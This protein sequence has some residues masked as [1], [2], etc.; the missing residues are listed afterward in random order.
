M[1]LRLRAAAAAILACVIAVSSAL[2]G[3]KSE[4]FKV[5]STLDGRKV[6]PLRIHWIAGPHIRSAKVEEVDFLI[7]GKVR[8]IEH[9]APYVYGG[10]DEGHNQGFLITTWLRP[11]KHRTVRVTNTRGLKAADTVIAQEAGRGP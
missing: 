9:K 4:P 1:S 8:W 6:L 2:A 11:G 10:D 7:D 5:S 3:G